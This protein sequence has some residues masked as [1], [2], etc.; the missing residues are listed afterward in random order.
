M[1]T[2]IHKLRDIA[3]IQLKIKNQLGKDVIGMSSHFIPMI[4][5]M[6]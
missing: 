3:E 6:F 1:D 5:S 2:H 4:H